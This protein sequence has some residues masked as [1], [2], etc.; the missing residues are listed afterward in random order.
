LLTADQQRVDG[1]PGA[2]HQRG[3]RVVD[4]GVSQVIEAPQ[5]DVGELADFER[6]DV[7]IATQAP[8]TVLRGQ[9]EGVARREGRRPTS[10]ARGQKGL[11]HL[12]R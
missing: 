1:G 10:R 6:A 4:S 9:S 11:P 12:Y 5:R 8:R 7:R 3:H 2:Q